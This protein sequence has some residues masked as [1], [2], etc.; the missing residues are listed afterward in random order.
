MTAKGMFATLSKGLSAGNLLSMGSKSD[1]RNETFKTNLSHDR[2]ET[3]DSDDSTDADSASSST[4]FHHIALDESPGDVRPYS[5]SNSTIGS[6][7]TN[8]SFYLP[9][10]MD[11]VSNYS[12]D[13]CANTLNKWGKSNEISPPILAP[14][15]TA[16]PPIPLQISVD[17]TTDVKHL[18][19]QA[20]ERE[21]IFGNFDFILFFIHS[22]T[23]CMY[24]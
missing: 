6:M 14:P 5:I 21:N 19:S 11:T 22:L 15:S 24:K 23:I 13:D 18:H 10:K 1:Q 3:S 9:E 12:S 7:G 16:P 17:E 20:E 8:D 2:M 4:S